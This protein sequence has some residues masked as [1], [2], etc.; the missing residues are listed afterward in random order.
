MLEYLPSKLKLG[1]VAHARTASIQ[2][3]NV[4]DQKSKVILSHISSL[5]PP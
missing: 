2:E 4:E 1:G 5:R 3:V